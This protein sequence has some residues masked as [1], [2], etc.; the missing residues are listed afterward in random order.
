MTCIHC[1][2]H[3]DAD[4]AEALAEMQKPMTCKSCSTETHCL[5]FMEYGHKTAGY[6]VR[7][8]NDPEQRRLAKRA[9]QRDR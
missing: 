9:F 8:G 2:K 6:L 3:L 7:V 4:R 1:G 5:C